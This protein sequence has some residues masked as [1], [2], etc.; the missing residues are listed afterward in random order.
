MWDKPLVKFADG[1]DP[2][3]REYKRIIAETHLTPREAL[4]LSYSDQCVGPLSRVTVIS[5]VLPA[6]EE[7]RRS[8]SKEEKVPSRLWSHMRW[9]GE[10]SN[11]ELR[12]HMTNY[13]RSLGYLA[14]APVIEPYFKMFKNER[15]AYSNWSERH[16]AY[17]AGQGSFGLSDGF[18]TERGIA[19]R[20]GSVVTNLAIPASARTVEGPYGNCLFYQGTACRACINRCP[21][22][23]ITESG[24]NKNKCSDYLRD[25]GYSKDQLQGGYDNDRSV[26]GCGMCQ[27]RVPCESRNPV[28]RKPQGS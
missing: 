26:A 19:H 21:A 9:Y 18:I 11:D 10:K 27:T 28:D 2:I 13:L 25:I 8:N 14:A 6:A 22:G 12:R 5:W 7:T 16:I 24:H 1:D 4:V 17:A 23:A 20:C 3:F 15:G